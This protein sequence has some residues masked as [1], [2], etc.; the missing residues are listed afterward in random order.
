MENGS[1]QT[2]LATEIFKEIKM[3][4][5]RWFI[6]FIVMVLL[7]I[8]T[9]IGFLWYLSLPAEQYDVSQE[10]DDRSFNMINGDGG[11]IS[12]STPEDNLQ[13]TDSPVPFSD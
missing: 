1:E 9:V 6:A 5:R 13:E 8:T 10:A 11:D 4:A 3:S 12:V 7:E 2:T